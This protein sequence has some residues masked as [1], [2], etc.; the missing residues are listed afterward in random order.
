MTVWG[1]L[2]INIFI[3]QEG[4][5]GY[6]YISVHSYRSHTYVYSYR[7]YRYTFIYISKKVVL[8]W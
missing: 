2:G 5:K 1:L 3:K 4:K 7:I 8:N 6:E